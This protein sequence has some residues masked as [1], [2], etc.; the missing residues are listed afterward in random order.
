MDINQ[1]PYDIWFEII[2]FQEC[3]PTL[4]SKH[5]KTAYELYIAKFTE[6]EV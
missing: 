2:Q 4:F 3:N 1:L 6:W 5:Y